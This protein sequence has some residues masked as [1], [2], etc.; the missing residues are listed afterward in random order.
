M[1]YKKKPQNFNSKFDVVSCFV[2]YNG[3]I[4]LLHRQDYKPEGNTWGVPAGKV[5]DGETISEA[6]I[7]EI[8]EEIGFVLSSSQLS[9]F[10]KVYVRYPDYDFIYHIFNTELDQRQK[11]TINRTEHKDFKWILPK[12]ALKMPLIQD[13]DA[14]I[15]LFYKS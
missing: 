8:Q 6:M 11:V 5:D 14:C 15:K 9:Y 12:D 13:L 2:Q 10:E 1:I 7:R 4:L 3:E